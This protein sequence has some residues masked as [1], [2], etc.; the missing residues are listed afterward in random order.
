MLPVNGAYLKSGLINFFLLEHPGL[1]SIYDSGYE[2]D[3]FYFTTNYNIQ[4]SLEDFIAPQLAKEVVLRIIREL[5]MALRY[6]EEQGLMHGAFSAGDIRFNEQGQALLVDFGIKLSF[7]LL[8]KEQT[9]AEQIEETLESLGLLFLSLLTGTQD[10]PSNRK[11]ILVQ[12]EDRRLKDIVT[13]LLGP[14]TVQYGSF[15]EILADL[16]DYEKEGQEGIVE[17]PAYESTAA[18]FPAE[19]PENAISVREKG[20]VL[21]QVRQ[22]ISEKIN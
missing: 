17:K 10:I 21:P 13:R 9:F 16:D 6:A 12:V 5:S 18:P 8:K 2:G 22:L 15:E 19:E 14:K 11:E 7:R 20:K 4:E 1:A 3:F